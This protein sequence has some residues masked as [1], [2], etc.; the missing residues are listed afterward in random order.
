MKTEIEVTSGQ[1]FT[2]QDAARVLMCSAG[3]VKR[4]ADELRLS[5]QRTVGGVRIFSA[6]Q[7]EKLRRERERRAREGQR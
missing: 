2:S 7:V 6:D 5:V 4:L 1:I 3:T